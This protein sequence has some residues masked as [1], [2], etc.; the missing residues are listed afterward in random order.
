MG[1]DRDCS[2]AVYAYD[3]DGVECVKCGGF[4]PNPEDNEGDD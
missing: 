3:A 2:R 1:H 4:W